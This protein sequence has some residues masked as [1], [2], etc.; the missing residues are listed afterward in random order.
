MRR[1]KTTV[2]TRLSISIDIGKNHN[3]RKHISAKRAQK[4]IETLGSISMKATAIPMKGSMASKDM[5]TE[6]FAHLIFCFIT[7]GF[8]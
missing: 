1:E 5:K 6:L 4:R 2:S 8:N 7:I 3:A